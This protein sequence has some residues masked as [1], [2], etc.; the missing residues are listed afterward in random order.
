M[1]TIKDVAEKAGVTVTTVSRVLNNRG[2]ISDKTREK[3]YEV[4]EQLNYQPN[5]L[6]RAL[7]KK[8]TNLIGLIIPNV[9]H[10][11]F[12]ELTS[13]I[14]N[15]AYNNDY[16][17]LLCNSSGNCDK[18]INYINM[19]IGKQVDGI[20]MGG[21]TLDT[22]IYK[23]INRPIVTIDR[24]IS[25]AIPNISSDNYYGGVLATNLL[26]K[27]GCKM[28]AHVRGPLYLNTPANRRAE[29]FVDVAIKNNI[30]YV[31]VE[32]KYNSF[33]MEEY[34]KL[35]Y[36]LFNDYPRIDGIFASND[37][38]ASCA[39]RIANELGKKIPIDLKIVGYDGIGIAAHLTPSLT[40]IQQPIK[41]IGKLAIQTIIDQL[42]GKVV[43]K[44]IILPVEIREGKTV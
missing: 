1:A 31:V 5:E 16:K 37:M 29:A 8:R 6:A 15:Y 43:N 27:K 36:Q 42:Q 4:M 32:T 7:F 39:I 20:I 23:N 33:K 2:Y 14:E 26:I 34:Y 13:Y 3:V 10:P 41:E 18:E 25:K 38:I 40:T 19:L 44:D 22:S 12:G 35:I 17:I 24:I 9:A 28:L 11:F 30:D 21:H